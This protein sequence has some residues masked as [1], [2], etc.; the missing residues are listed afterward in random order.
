MGIKIFSNLPSYVKN[1]PNN[2]KKF[3]ICLKRYLRIYYFYSIEEYIQ[4]KSNTS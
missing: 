2:V 4:Y 1:I 3:E